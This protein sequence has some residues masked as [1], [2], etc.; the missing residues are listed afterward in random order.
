MEKLK[1]EWPHLAVLGASFL[2]LPALSGLAGGGTALVVL[3]L[4]V[5]PLES[6][7]CGFFAGKAGGF[8]WWFF[9]GAG[10]LFTSSI[11]MYY[12]TSSMYS[13]GGIYALLALAANAFGGYIASDKGTP[14]TNWKRKQAQKK[15][16]RPP[17]K[18]R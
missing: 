16:S 10:V 1:K 7:L 9:L 18:L 12:N 8:A 4:V 13:Y 14:D 15:A 6:L 3:L 2:V 5:F 17:K 11:P